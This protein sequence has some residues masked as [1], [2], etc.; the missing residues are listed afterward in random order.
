MVDF[1]IQEKISISRYLHCSKK[2]KNTRRIQKNLFNFYKMPNNRESFFPTF[3]KLIFII[4]TL[5]DQ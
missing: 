3:S 1:E 5:R 2:K 4:F